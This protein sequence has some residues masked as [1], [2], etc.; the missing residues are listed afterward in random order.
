MNLLISEIL[1]VDIGLD[2]TDSWTDDQTS[3]VSVL[4]SECEIVECHDDPPYGGV[5]AWIEPRLAAL[6]EVFTS[7]E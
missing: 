7:R 4:S 2:R 5:L 1:P 3:Y 6:R